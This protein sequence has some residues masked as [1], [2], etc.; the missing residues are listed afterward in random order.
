MVGKTN[1]RKLKLSTIKFY[2]KVYRGCVIIVR[3]RSYTGVFSAIAGE[4]IGDLAEALGQSRKPAALDLYESKTEP[5]D[6]VAVPAPEANA[7]NLLLEWFEKGRRTRSDLGKLLASRQIDVPQGSRLVIELAP[8]QDPDL[9]QVIRIRLKGAQF[10]ATKK[11]KPRK[12]AA[13]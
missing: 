10:E 13:N 9:G 2:Q 12:T 7:D 1:T 6:V 4:L 3:D 5:A 8:D 11:G